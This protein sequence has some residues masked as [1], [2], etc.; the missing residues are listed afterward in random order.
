MQTSTDRERSDRDGCKC[1]WSV[2]IESFLE[3]VREMSGFIY[4][5]ERVEIAKFS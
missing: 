1:V 5:K 4:L 2:V 3:F